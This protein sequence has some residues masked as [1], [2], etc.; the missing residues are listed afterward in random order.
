MRD[1]S[2]NEITDYNQMFSVPSV[3]PS[4][5]TKVRA[6]SSSL[7]S[8]TDCHVKQS[9]ST[10]FS[11]TAYAASL[12]SPVFKAMALCHPDIAVFSV[13]SRHGRESHMLHHAWHAERERERERERLLADA[14]SP[15]SH[16]FM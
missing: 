5:D 8:G 13:T 2:A 9:L 7:S 1:Y 15:Q 11:D 12:A 16:R 6:A 10:G 3:T 4:L 14:F